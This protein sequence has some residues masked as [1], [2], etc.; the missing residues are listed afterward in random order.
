MEL[1]SHVDLGYIAR[2]IRTLCVEGDVIE[3][4]VLG[5]PR[6]GPISGYF[7]DFDRLTFAVA[8]Y[9]SRAEA[10]YFTLNPVQ[11]A[12][13]A[14]GDN[15]LVEWAKH[16]TSDADIVCRR[17]MLIDLDPARPAGISSSD[18]ELQA[19]LTR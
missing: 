9:D 13:L 2:V 10:T 4:R 3:V 11:P 16:T 6:K 8:Q 18:V 19:A 5:V 1:P 7:N 14:R 17:G 12:L 15:R